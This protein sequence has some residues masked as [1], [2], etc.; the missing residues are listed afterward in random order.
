MDELGGVC[1]P[2]GFWVGKR[3]GR[4]LLERRRR[5]WMDDIKINL[6]LRVRWRGTRLS[7]SRRRQFANTSEHG[8]EPSV[9]IKFLELDSLTFRGPCNAIY[10]YNK[11]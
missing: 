9:Y 3:E 11:S 8:N 7:V 4:G 6:K 2:K 5:A 10:S 1:D